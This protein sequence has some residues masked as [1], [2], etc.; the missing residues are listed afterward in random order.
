MPIPGGY[1]NINNSMPGYAQQHFPSAI[2][3]GKNMSKNKMPMDD[4]DQK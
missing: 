2:A 4:Y 1:N 3:T